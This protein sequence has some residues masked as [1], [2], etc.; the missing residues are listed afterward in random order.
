MSNF[1]DT[2]AGLLSAIWLVKILFRGLTGVGFRITVQLGKVFL[3]RAQLVEGQLR[4]VSNRLM[5]MEASRLSAVE[6]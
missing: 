4:L 5:P 2:G 6:L 1:S 3:L